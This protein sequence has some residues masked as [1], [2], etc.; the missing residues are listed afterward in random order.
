MRTRSMIALLSVLGLTTI[1]P[2]STLT[3]RASGCQYTSIN[4][5]IDAASR[6][7]KFADREQKEAYQLLM[8]I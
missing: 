5:A 8:R 1:A 6:A 7:A 3:V 4:D 2:A